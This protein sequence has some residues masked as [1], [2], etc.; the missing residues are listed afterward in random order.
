MLTAGEFDAGGAGEAV[1]DG[2]SIALGTG[3]EAVLQQQVEDIEHAVQLRV[4]V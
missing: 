4:P 1:E 2:A 3:G